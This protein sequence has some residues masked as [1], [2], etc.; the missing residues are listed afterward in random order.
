MT[1]II[2]QQLDGRQDILDVD[3]GTTLMQ[4][5]VSRGLRGIVGECG[6]AAMCATCHVFVEP[7]HLHRLPA[8]NAVEDGMLD[9]VVDERQFNSR[10]SCQLMAT[11]ELDG[12]IVH[13]PRTQV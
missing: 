3:D 9:S 6:G 4:A 7:S 1:R 12:L 2:Y 11:P 8:M 5:A 13:I 10:L